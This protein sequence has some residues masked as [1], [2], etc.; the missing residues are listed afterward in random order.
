MEVLQNVSMCP[1]VHVEEASSSV[2]IQP[3]IVSSQDSVAER[4]AHVAEPSCIRTDQYP[5]GCRVQ[6]NSRVHRGTTSLVWP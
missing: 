1:C 5:E 2:F 3:Y 6:R 4:R